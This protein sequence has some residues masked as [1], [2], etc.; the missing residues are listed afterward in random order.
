[1]KKNY[2][3]VLILLALMLTAS[4]SAIAYQQTSNC[5]QGD[6]T[7]NLNLGNDPQNL[8]WVIYDSNTVFH[9]A[10]NGYTSQQANT[11]ITTTIT[12]QFLPAGDYNFAIIN[13]HGNGMDG[14]SYTLSYNGDIL[15]T[16]VGNSFTYSQAN[17]FCYLTTNSSNMDVTPPSNPNGL[18]I[19]NMTTNT[20]GISWNASVDLQSP[21][22][23]YAIVINGDVNNS[24]QT[25]NTNYTFSNLT[26]GVNYDVYVVAK[27]GVGN[28]S[29][30]ST[31]TVTINTN[32]Q[33]NCAQGSLTLD[34]NFD[35]NPQDISWFI[36]DPAVNIVQSGNTY[37][38][39]AITIPINGL[40]NGDYVFVIQD[41]KGDGN[42]TYSLGNTS[43]TVAS[44]MS[45]GFT[46]STQFCIGAT[47]GNTLDTVL[48]SP[49]SNVIA[50]NITQT[51]LELNWSPSTDNV[52]VFQYA[53]LKDNVF[54]GST[55]SNTTSQIVNGLDPNTSY[56]F[57]VLARDL[58]G[59]ISGSN[60]LTV[61]TLSNVS[62]TILHQGFFEN[63]FDGWT[64]GGNDCKRVNNS[65]RSYE[66]D[67]SMRLR[68][69]S[70][71]ASSMTLTNQNITPF[72]AVELKFF[73]QARGMETGKQFLVKYN[74]GTNWTTVATFVRNSTFKNSRFYEVNIILNSSN[75]TF[76][77]NAQFR[78]E[79]DGDVNNDRIFVDQTSLI[80]YTGSNLASS[81][82]ITEV[83][84]SNRQIETEV[85]EDIKPLDLELSL[86]PNPATSYFSIKSNSEVLSVKVLTMT[87]NIEKTLASTNHRFDISNLE[88]GIYFIYIETKNGS[89]I[90]R[91]IIK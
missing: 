38:Q 62:T 51:S 73:V 23:S 20:A 10:G 48:P 37:N 81:S 31:N 33:S 66:N 69:N 56:D 21:S 84:A 82:S 65:N 49:P 16:S 34:L 61:S 22:V 5:A 54:I 88:S 4:Y 1:M 83:I 67:W 32:S 40:S 70:G 17:T 57:K 15:A 55:Y 58:V 68:D 90:K 27:D 91:L 41:I 46:E 53:I 78:I 28:F 3:N 50:S 14:G 24:I 2:S 74:D 79:N 86:Y 44:G 47:N 13:S 85:K 71:V 6:L 36:I 60:T 12:T 43:T 9:I 30:S 19:T 75:Y 39:S 77:N 18:Q 52:G 89:S 25:S 59:N 26:P 64:D 87:G 63:G 72:N 76:S 80:G 11:T 8:N 29:V 35:S 7:L 45:F 42:T